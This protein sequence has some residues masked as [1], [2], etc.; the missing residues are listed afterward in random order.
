MNAG[1]Y[2]KAQDLDIWLD[3]LQASTGCKIVIITEACK[4]G[5]FIEKL[6]PIGD[7][8]RI[9]IS[10]SSTEDSNY[11]QNGVLSFSGFFLDQVSQGDSLRNCFFKARK[12][13]ETITCSENRNPRSETNW[14]P[15]PDPDPNSPPDQPVLLSPADNETNVSLTPVLQTRPFSDPDT[16][17]SHGE[18]RWQISETEGFSE[19]VLL[20]IADTESLTELQMEEGELAENTKYFWR[21]MFIDNRQGSSEWS[22]PFRFHTLIGSDP[23]TPEPENPDSPTETPDPPSEPDEGMDTNQTGEPGDNQDTGTSE[24]NQTSGDGGGGGCF[25]SALLFF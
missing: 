17:D 23:E 18:T 15:E 12:E 13:W 11:D 21:V 8:Q 14:Q 2:L 24:E 1:E 7:Q 25:I 19:P 4:S 6:L 22:V 10:S 9:L 16:G 5:T 3:N 20:D